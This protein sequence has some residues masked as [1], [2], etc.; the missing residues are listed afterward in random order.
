MKKTSK[1]VSRT[2]IYNI[3]K[4]GKKLEHK[5]AEIFN[6]VR[7]FYESKWYLWRL[8]QMTGKH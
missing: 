7:I 6:Q 4:W 8:C 3:S 2:I 5:K 1:D